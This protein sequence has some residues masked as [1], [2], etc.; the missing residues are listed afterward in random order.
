MSKPTGIRPITKGHAIRL[1]YLNVLF[2]LKELLFCHYQMY[3]MKD[4][5]TKNMVMEVT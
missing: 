1:L 2:V 5:A 4:K 3:E